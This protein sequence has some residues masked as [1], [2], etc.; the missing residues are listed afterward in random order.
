[1]PCY[2]TS[3]CRVTCPAPPVYPA[4]YAPPARLGSTRACRSPP[5]SPPLGQAI[6]GQY[7]CPG[8]RPATASQGNAGTIGS[9]SASERVLY[10]ADGG[11]ITSSITCATPSSSKTA[12]TPPGPA[13][14][15]TPSRNARASGRSISRRSPF[16][17]ETRERSK[18]RPMLESAQRVVKGISVHCVSLESRDILLTGW[19]L[20]PAE[21]ATRELRNDRTGAEAVLPG[22]IGREC[23]GGCVR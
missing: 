18:R 22:K 3:A 19:Y 12:G 2:L 20:R 1:M 4:D 6:P 21:Q 13:K 7:E 14:R 11:P 10:P 17:N 16:T 15:A 8:Q 23:R 9:L 5:Y